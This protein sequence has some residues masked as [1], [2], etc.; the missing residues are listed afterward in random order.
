MTRQMYKNVMRLVPV[1][2]SGW[3][4]QSLGE[5][6]AAA[7]T[8]F[9]MVNKICFSN[10]FGSLPKIKLVHLLFIKSENSV[11]VLYWIE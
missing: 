6:S 9:N 1:K 10:Q 2:R 3:V 11:I 5:C 8:S 7:F 4:V